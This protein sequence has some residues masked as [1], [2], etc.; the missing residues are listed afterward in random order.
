VSTHLTAG[1]VVASGTELMFRLV[2]TA[3][4]T[5]TLNNWGMVEGYLVDAP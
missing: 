2:G 3:G 4:G 5:P 1:V